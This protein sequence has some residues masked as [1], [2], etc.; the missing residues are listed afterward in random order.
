MLTQGFRQFLL[1]TTFFLV[2]FMLFSFIIGQGIVASALLMKFYIYIYGGM[3]YILLFSILGFVLLEL[4]SHKY[5]LSN[6]IF[7]IISLFC[8]AGFYVLELNI[9]QISP[10]IANI[11][12]IHILFLSIFAFLGLGIY[13]LEFISN[14]INKFKK[15]ISYFL[16]FGIIVYS[17]MK[18]VWSLWPYLSLIVL[19]ANVFLLDFFGNV[20]IINE[21]TI[22]F[23]NFSAQIAEACSGVYSIFIFTALYL[24]GIILDWHKLNKKKAILLFIPA[25]IG[26]FIINILRVFMIFIVG[27]FISRQLALELFHSYI[28][29][30]LFLV[31]FGVFWS[32]SYKWMKR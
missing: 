14:F 3:G 9:N 29:M 27:A 28:G 30:V 6:L 25:V 4:E 8:L 24:F 18:P 17:L 7:I 13:G 22:F 15:Q 12:L 23:N 2:L 19:K 20:M 31:Y 32:L 26:A 10:T 16:I 5:K 21:S 1:K 11:I